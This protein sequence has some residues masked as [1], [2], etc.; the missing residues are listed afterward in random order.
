MD[1]QTLLQEAKHELNLKVLLRLDPLIDKIIQTTSHVVLYHF[2]T[3]TQSWTKRNIEGSLF[4]YKKN[5]DPI[6][7]ACCILNRVGL[8]NW[9]LDIDHE[10]QIQQVGDYLMYKQESSDLIHGYALY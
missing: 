7:F 4:L 3:I 2:D 8:D 1:H 9:L 10:L 6:S 5:T